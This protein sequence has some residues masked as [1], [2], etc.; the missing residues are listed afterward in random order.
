MSRV[1]RAVSSLQ[2]SVPVRKQVPGV[3]GVQ[4][5]CYNKRIK[6]QGEIEGERGEMKHHKVKILIKQPIKSNGVSNGD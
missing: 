6:S 4:R 5:Q 3:Q 2:L 1:A